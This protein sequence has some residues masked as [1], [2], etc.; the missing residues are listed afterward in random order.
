[1]ART[2]VHGRSPQAVWVVKK[3]SYEWIVVALAAAIGFA[4]I[5]SLLTAVELSSVK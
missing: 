5:F 1:M 3:K 4:I 2:A